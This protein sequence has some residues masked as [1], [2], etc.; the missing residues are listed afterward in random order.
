MESSVLGTQATTG[1]TL[2]TAATFGTILRPLKRPVLPSK[3]YEPL[4][5]EE[6]VN[7]PSS[8]LYD[9]TTMEAW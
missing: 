9:Y 2:I 3:D 1:N 4:L 7:Q 6:S 8:T 5:V